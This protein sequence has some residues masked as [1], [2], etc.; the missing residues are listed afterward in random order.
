MHKLEPG[1][2]HLFSVVPGWC[3][4]GTVD[5]LEGDQVRLSSAWWVETLRDNHVILDVCHTDDMRKVVD[6]CWFAGELWINMAMVSFWRT[7]RTDPSQLG[8]QHTDHDSFSEWNKRL[9]DDA[10]AT[11]LSQ[12]EYYH[13][14][15]LKEL[16]DPHR[17]ITARIKP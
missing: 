14:G 8:F 13:N 12:I 4:V 3:I 9:A 11:S 2:H 7:T 6:R 17:A 1:S 10:S 5:R 15:T 16:Y